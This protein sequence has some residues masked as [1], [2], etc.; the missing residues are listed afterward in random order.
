MEIINKIIPF[1]NAKYQYY[2]KLIILSVFYRNNFTKQHLN[3]RSSTILSV[4]IFQKLIGINRHVRFPVHF[5]NTIGQTGSLDISITSTL[6]LATNT[7]IYLQTINGLI[8]KN[9]T[10]I[11]T[12]TKIISANHSKDDLDKHEKTKP[13][14]IG[15]NCW[16]G[17]NSV[18]LPEVE[19]ANNTVVGA[20]SIVTKSVK[21]ENTTIAGNPAKNIKFNNE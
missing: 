10:I 3:L 18:I 21:V 15:E 1:I 17:A 11:A 5:T 14:I 6:S 13:I 4:F 2:I 7:G 12:G 20:G 8:I 19:L 9:N 16:V